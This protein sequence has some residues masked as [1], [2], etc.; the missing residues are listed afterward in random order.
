[1]AANNQ[2]IAHYGPQGRPYCGRIDGHILIRDAARF[3]VEARQCKRC[4]K[5]LAEARERTRKSVWNP[6]GGITQ[7]L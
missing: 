7:G 6:Q 3:D 2:C 4:A 1:M 5:K